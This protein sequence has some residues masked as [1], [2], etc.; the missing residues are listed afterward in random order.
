MGETIVYFIY[1]AV[2]TYVFFSAR[3][4]ISAFHLTVA[5]SSQFMTPASRVSD[6]SSFFAWM[7]QSTL[8]T[9]YPGGPIM[10]QNYQIG[11]VQLRQVRT[12]DDSCSVNAMF[13]D[14]IDT[15]YRPSAVSVESQRPLDRKLSPGGPADKEAFTYRDG[16]VPGFDGKYQSYSG[17]GFFQDFVSTNV[18][19]NS[20]VLKD[21]ADN[22]WLDRGT[23]AVF[24]DFSLYNP[25]WN[26][27][28]IATIAFEFSPSGACVASGKF[29]TVELFYYENS[30]AMMKM[31][32]EAIFILFLFYYIWYEISEMRRKPLKEYVGSIWNWVE[33]L[34]ALIFLG[35]IL[36]R[37]QVVNAIY[38][39]KPDIIE[40]SPAK[41]IPMQQLAWYIQSE[42]S[43][44]AFNS[45]MV[46]LKVRC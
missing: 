19:S 1:L 38:V 35:V 2:F 16:S 20:A 23:R 15:C 8:P 42:L 9:L 33:W 7:D 44:L 27:Y 17:N 45:F 11:A 4:G 25:N 37:Y 26:Y 30:G 32:A 14:K 5:A 43:V 28:C 34:N 31:G 39:M 22:S 10:D 36:G 12:D 41:F 40:A 3:P 21:L 6:P 13:A 24:V 46:Y 18:T 29:R